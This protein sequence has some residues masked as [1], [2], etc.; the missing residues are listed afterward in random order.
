[1]E[2]ERKEKD[3]LDHRAPMLAYER[4]GASIQIGRD[5]WLS[6]NF[7][8]RAHASVKYQSSNPSTPVTIITEIQIIIIFPT[9]HSLW[10]R[11]FWVIVSG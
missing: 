7:T 5:K 1:M 4:W 3:H 2:E 10:S 6:F 11:V 9:C 8:A